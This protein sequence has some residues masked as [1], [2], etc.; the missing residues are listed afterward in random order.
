MMRR[1]WFVAFLLALGSG[2]TR[3]VVTR[4]GKILEGTVTREGAVVVVATADGP[5]RLPA[6]TV[7]AIFE[8]YPDARREAASRLGQAKKLFEEAT[9][10]PDH[11]PLRRR[12]LAVSLDICRETRDLIQI[13]EGHTSAT[14]RAE[15]IELMRQLP[16]LMRLVRDAKG[17]T[18]TAEGSLDDP[19]EPVPLD[20]LGLEVKFPSTTQDPTEV[21]EALGTGQ[22]AMIGELA[23]TEPEARVLAARKLTSPPAP[24]ALPALSKVMQKESD[25]DVLAALVEAIARLDVEPHLKSEF[26]WMLGEDELNRRIAIIHLGRRLPSRAACDFLGECFR[27]R[28]P[29]HIQV[30]VAFASAFRKFRPRSIEVLR[31]ALVKSKDVAARAEVVRQLGVL[32]D[33]AALPLLKMTLVPAAGAGGSPDLFR[34]SIFAIESLGKASVPL[35]VELMGDPNSAIKRQAQALAKRIT[36]EEVDGIDELQKWWARNRRYVD[37]DEKEFWKEQEKKDFPV[38]A[39]EFRIFERR[40]PDPRD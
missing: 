21:K 22:V 39:D 35:L 30:R 16:Q 26:A 8:T 31:E 4:D 1:L 32:R 9:A 33:R 37:E 3:T 23:S 13:L 27:T 25:R 12:L 7:V 10:K 5:V 18:A 34:V 29:T 15:L 6:Q 11:D 36:E 38:G 20:S 40:L 14:E 24:H 28:P 19:I 17:A 2:G